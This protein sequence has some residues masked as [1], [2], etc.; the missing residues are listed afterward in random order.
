MNI[1]YYKNSLPDPDDK[2]E[3]EP[4]KTKPSYNQGDTYKDNER[5]NNGKIE[6]KNQN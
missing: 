2:P 5:E 4:E 3:S 1:N 6:K